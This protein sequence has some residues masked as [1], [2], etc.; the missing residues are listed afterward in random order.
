MSDTFIETFIVVNVSQNVRIA[1][2]D[3]FLAGFAR[4]WWKRIEKRQ[5]TFLLIHSRALG[6]G[7]VSEIAPVTD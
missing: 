6:S 4:K 5:E 2:L 1:F 3:T 7:N